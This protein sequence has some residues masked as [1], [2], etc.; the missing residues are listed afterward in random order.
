LTTLNFNHNKLNGTIP[1]SLGNLVQLT[2]L[3]LSENSLTGA[4]PAS[5]GQLKELVNVALYTNL[6]TGLVPSLPFAQ[7][8]DQCALDSCVDGK[9]CNQYKCPL[10]ANAKDCVFGGTVT[11]PGVHCK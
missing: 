9:K 1:A 8:T 7:W 10:P 4:I 2:L 5:L 6:L 3:D 11:G